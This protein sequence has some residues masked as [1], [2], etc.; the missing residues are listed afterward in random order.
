MSDD[1]EHSHEDVDVLR[2]A[3]VG[4]SVVAVNMTDESSER[5]GRWGGPTVE[6]EVTLDNGT[7]L[8]LAGNEGGCAC[9]AGDYA[10][11]RLNDMPVNGIMDVEVDVV[12]ATCPDDCPRKD[13]P[14]GDCWEHNGS[15]YRLFVLAQDDRIELATFE[16]DDSD[17]YGTG[18]WFT[19]TNT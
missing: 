18:F 9:S 1:Q 4:R 19:V 13:A 6:G 16:G 12:D 14:A 17:Y 3:L 10:L 8:K 15:V 11:T 2:A 7:V 5:L